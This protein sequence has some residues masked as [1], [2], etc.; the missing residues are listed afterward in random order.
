MKSFLG[1][2]WKICSI[3]ERLIQ[4]NQQDYN[5]SYL[6]SKIFLQRKFSKE[7]I[8]SSLNKKE[9]VNIMYHSNDFIKAANIFDECVKQNEKIL[10]FGDYDVDGYSSTFLLYDYIKSL[11]I[12]CEFYIPD[13]F[14]DGYGPNIKLLSKLVNKKKYQ[15]VIFVDCASN[16]SNEINY[17][18]D[19][20]IKTIVI[21]H[22][23][24]YQ[25]NDNKNSIIINPLKKNN[26]KR[27]SILC[28]T[29]LVYFFIKYLESYYK[30]NLKHNNKYLFFS[31]LATICDQMPLR[32]I[33]RII[34]KE[35]LNNFNIKNF[36]NL[37]KILKLKSKISS[38][39]LG[40]HLGPVLNSAARLGY[41]D[42]PIKLFIETDNNNLNVISDKLINLN[43]K[44]KKIQTELFNSLNQ[45]LQIKQDEVIFKFEEN[46]NEGLL[47]I[48]ASNFVEI[49][50]KP[51]FILTN[52]NYEIKCSSR[53]IHGFNIGKLF[54]EAINKN[55]LLKGGG[56]SMA[57]G[58]TLYKNKI[59]E[60][61]NYINYIFKKKFKDFK[62]NKYYISEQNISSLKSF[63]KLDLQKLEPLGNNNE[64][65]FFLI[66]QNKIIKFKIINNLHLQ[67]LIRNKFR[68]TCLCIAF[69]V[70]ETKLGDI[71]MNYKKEIDLIVQIN[72]KIIRKNS[73]FNLIIKDA[74]L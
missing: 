9:I 53:S 46:I 64:N 41:A 5:I 7:E 12:K 10:I 71:L 44:R 23:Q 42:L 66:K 60:F 57:G 67:I 47:G 4:K 1:I 15:L 55:I 19:L 18:N 61:K 63:A 30:R 51:S 43:L 3:P 50:G 16:S 58:C 31:A 65:P 6:L 29:S 48:I 70:I 27:F 54:S 56:H 33:N 13:R 59:Y 22:H 34:V 72:N 2:S 21:D 37:K 52:S 26:S 28:A 40:F 32:N 39:D 35:S 17:L 69:N 24:I 49:Y 8:H 62:N 36:Y 25:N 11:N 74:I 14:K 38:N 73:D 45:K 68:K 20:G